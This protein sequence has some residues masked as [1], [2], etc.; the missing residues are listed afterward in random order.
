M[1][2][3]TVT[4]RV[5]KGDVLNSYKTFLIHLHVTPGADNISLVKWSIEY[6]KVNQDVADPTSFLDALVKVSKQANDYLKA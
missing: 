6:E 3:R 2:K 5:I 1:E 4:Y